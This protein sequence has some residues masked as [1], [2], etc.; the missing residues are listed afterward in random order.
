M[1]TGT[2]ARDVASGMLTPNSGSSGTGNDDTVSV[3]P[4]CPKLLRAPITSGRHHD[5]GKHV[6]DGLAGTAR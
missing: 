3:A 1:N 6:V 2:H 4:E 5:A